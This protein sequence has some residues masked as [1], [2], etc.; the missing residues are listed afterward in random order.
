M[1]NLVFE[2]LSQSLLVKLPNGETVWCSKVTLGCPLMISGM[3]LK[4]D[5]IM[6]K[7]LEFDIILGMDWLYQYFASINCRSRIV[8]FQLP[9]GEYLEFAGSKV[10]SKPTVISAI[11]ASRD[12]ASGADAFLVQVMSV[13]SEK[14]FLAKIPIVEEFSDVFVDDLPGLPPVRDLEFAIDLE[15]GAAPVHKAPYRMAPAELK[16]LKSQLQELDQ[17]IPKTAF[18]SR[19]GHYEFKVMPFGLANAPAAFMDMMNRVFRLYLD[20]FVIVFIDDILVY[21]RDPEQH[22]SHLRLVLSKLREHQLYAN[23]NKCEFWLEE[24]KFLGHVMSR[25]GVAVDPSKIEAVLAWPRPSTV[26]EIRSFLGLAGYYRRF[27]EGFARLSG[28]LTSLTRKNVEFVWSDK[29]EKSFQELKKR[30]TTAPVL[31]LPE[32]HKPFVVFSDASK[33]GLGCVLM[34]EGKVVAYASRQLKDHE[35]NYPTHDLELAAVVFALK[36]W[37]YYL[38]G[39]T[40]EIFTDHKSLKH[41]FSQKNLNMRQRRWLELISDYQCEIKYHPAALGT[42][43]KFS[44]AYH[45]Q[46]D[47]QSERT[48]Q[49]LEDMLRACVLDFKGSWENHLSLIEFAY[50]NSFQATI[51]MAPYEALYGRKCRSPLFWDEV[52][53]GNL[54]GPEIIQEMRNQVQVIRNKMAAAQSRQKSY[55]DTRRRDLLFEGGDWV[56]LKVSPMKGVKRFGKKGKLSPRYVGPFQILEKVGPV[57]YRIAL[58]EYFGEIHDV[59]HVSSLKKSFGQQ[60]PRF[61]DPGSIQLRPD[62]TYEVVP[63]QILDRKEQQLRSKSIPLVMVSWGD[64]LAQDFSWEREVDMRKFYPYLFG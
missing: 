57:A 34:Q 15:S 5:L 4:A 3:I 62:L 10:K 63:T 18:R 16:E 50:N 45:P 11:Q 41:L 12:L 13:L 36:I 43:L 26:H 32:P 6:F 2:P 64:P 48:I 39:E 25:D 14:K 28:P 21:S 1:C 61:V 46:T 30:L 60:E 22:A 33:F 53:E 55:S 56:Y 58:P 7:L 59:F 19:Y 27:V 8:S 31:A 23:L 44:S 51:Q 47:G 52:G 35:R 20:S 9:G 24:I 54:L 29:C 42:K 40:C 38:Y 49:T 17:D 37:R